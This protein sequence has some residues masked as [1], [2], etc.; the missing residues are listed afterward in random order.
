MSPTIIGDFPPATKAVSVET[1]GMTMRF[2]SP[3]MPMYDRKLSV[4]E[5]QARLDR[6]YHPYHAAVKAAC[7]AE[8]CS[9][10]SGL[11]R[12]VRAMARILM[13]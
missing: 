13:L 3:G 2:G 12:N 11:G 10:C 7:R 4:A 5:V 6:Y 8:S 9:S 1:I